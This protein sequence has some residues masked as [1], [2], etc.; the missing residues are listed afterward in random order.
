MPK[1][2][3]S[4]CGESL[5]AH[6]LR[7]V[8]GC[9]QVEHVIIVAPPSHLEQCRAVAGEDRRVD[10]VAGGADRSASVQAGL[11]A[12]GRHDTIVLVHDVARCLAPPE[13]FARVISLVRGGCP[14]VVPG[15]GVTDTVKVVDAQG[16]VLQTPQRER[17][18]AIQTP[19]GFRR[20]VLERAYASG[21]SATDDAGLVE[22]NG[23]QV[24]VVDGDHR[25]LKIT[26]PLDL[27]VAA[28]LLQEADH[29]R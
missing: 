26:S 12:L 28:A 25:A 4:L 14:A 6:A 9:A 19:Q 11:V 20:D 10:I 17:L 22:R 1:A 24:R 8:L 21:A 5:L 3:A 13:L 18:R 7:G 2:F 27:S 15:L 29:V 16:C 23:G